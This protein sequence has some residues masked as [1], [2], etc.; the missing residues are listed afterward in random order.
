MFLADEDLLS[1]LI[2]LSIIIFVALIYIFYLYWRNKNRNIEVSVDDKE[3]EKLKIPKSAVVIRYMER[4]Q[5]AF[6][7]VLKAAL[8][9]NYIILP[10]VPIE[11]LFEIY[12]RSELLMKGQYA[13]FVIF[14]A[15]YKP[16]LVIDLFD[17][18]VLNLEAVNKI[19]SISKSVMRSSGIVVFDFKLG[20]HY[21]IDDLRRQIANAMNPLK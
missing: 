3:A 4:K 7:D 9:S 16:L 13:D 5:S 15:S 2:P 21:D 6:Y 12:K 20:D 18:S 14:D 11:K 17:M 10:N 8:P 1:V 19:K